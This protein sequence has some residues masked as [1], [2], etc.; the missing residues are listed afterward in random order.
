MKFCIG[1]FYKHM[2][3]CATFWLKFG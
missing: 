2:F 3:M 1:D